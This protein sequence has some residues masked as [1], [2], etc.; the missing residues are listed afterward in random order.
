MTSKVTRY[1]QD[2]V[3]ALVELYIGVAND[4]FGLNLKVPEV[5]WDVRGT[6]AGRAA[7]LDGWVSF[8]PVLY[9]E[10]KHAFEARTVPHEVAHMVAHMVAPH[11]AR[12]SRGKLRPHGLEWHKVMHVFGK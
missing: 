9:S 6:T 2:K 7:P 8:N 3:R 5:R 11:I 10:S 4:K 12:S 1:E